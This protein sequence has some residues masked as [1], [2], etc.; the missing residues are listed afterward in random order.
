MDIV[1]L[2]AGTVGKSIAELLCEKGHSVTV[3]DT[4]PRKTRLINEELD[5]R[6]I[7]GS[8]S[9]SSV[10][11]QTG[12]AHADICLAVTGVDEVNIIAASM[13]R[14]MGTRRSIARVYAP[15]FRDLSTFDY[16]EHF[17]IDRLLSLEHLS[18]MQL[19]AKFDI[20]WRDDGLFAKLRFDPK[21]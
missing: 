11:S 1:V 7:T 21:G 14:S 16:Q 20:E 5:V 3:V 15:V 17:H 6:A 19:A 18:A 2:G 10:L 4:D 12:A 8:A 9:Q 13:A